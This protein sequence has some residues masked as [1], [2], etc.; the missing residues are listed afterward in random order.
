[1]G[2]VI[3]GDGV[4]REMCVDETHLV[5]ESLGVSWISARLRRV[6]QAKIVRD[7]EEDEQELGYIQDDVDLGG[8]NRQ[9]TL[10]DRQ[11]F[12][13]HLSG[14]YRPLPSD[15]PTSNGPIHPPRKRRPSDLAI[16]NIPARQPKP[17][18]THPNL[19]HLCD[20]GNHVLDQRLDSPQ[21]RNVLSG[22]VPYGKDDFGRLGGFDLGLSARFRRGKRARCASAG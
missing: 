7:W 17:S 9:R 1:M 16:S 15:P 20:T 19:T 12:G 10:P 2:S 18:S 6:G 4:D 13:G 14:C 11:G 5:E 22:T 8:T 3:V 21:A